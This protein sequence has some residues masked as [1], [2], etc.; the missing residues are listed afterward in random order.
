ME[1]LLIPVASDRYALELRTVR[2]VLATPELTPLPGA[3]AAV[4]GLFNLR[5]TIV[6]LLD[7]SLLLGLGRMDPRY[8]AVADTA[9]GP[10]ALSAGAMPTTARLEDLAGPAE[11]P[12]AVARF[13]TADGGVATLLD[14]DALL[15]ALRA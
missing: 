13:A 9:E 10:A 2:E 4:C 8:V 14:L 11:L 15:E 1:A 12:G 6:P 7:T 5:G 3:P